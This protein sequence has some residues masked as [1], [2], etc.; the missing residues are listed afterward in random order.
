[1]H[2][3]KH[4]LF[5]DSFWSILTDI[6]A[7]MSIPSLNLED[8]DIKHIAYSCQKFLFLIENGYSI[9]IIATIPEFKTCIENLLLK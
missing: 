2:L 9:N 5:S 4:R 3:L 7:R 1:M 8:F 6:I